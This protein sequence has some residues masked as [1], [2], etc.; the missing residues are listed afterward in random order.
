[1][2]A[3]PSGATNVDGATARINSFLNPEP[4]QP[5]GEGVEEQ[6]APE[7]STEVEATATET[8]AEESEGDTEIAVERYKV[9]VGGDELD[10]TLEDLQKGYMM[11]S[12]YRKKTT[13]VA[14]RS[15]ALE[16]KEAKIDAQLNEAQA[17][18]DA[19]LNE[20]QAIVE[21][22]IQNLE[23]AEMKE[24]K[25]YDPEAYLK[26]VDKT[27]SRVDKF[28]ALKN[29][30]QVEQQAR[31]QE[32]TKKELKS[33][34]TAIPEWLDP[35]VRSKEANEVFAAMEQ[36]GFSRD[37]LS[38]LTDHRMFVLARKA[39]LFDQINGSDLESKKVRTPPKS[40]SPGSSAQKKT[41]SEKATADLRGKL[42]KS[43]SAKDAAN[44]FRSMMK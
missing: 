24:L 33:L 13:D 1:M 26:A 4:E 18:I 27:R 40:Q 34:E 30:R 12:D 2:E 22:E 25:E 11:E 39:M 43:G 16:G 37:E 7:E 23:S 6:H 38:S 42:R 21:F 35:D 41:A 5:T 28:N 14:E 19:Q 32:N 29:Q 9:K 44:L 31:H 36:Q 8:P 17:K 3:N 20:A 15:K 10:V